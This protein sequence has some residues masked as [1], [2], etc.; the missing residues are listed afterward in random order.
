MHAI[1]RFFLNDKNILVLILINA[2]II[3]LQGFPPTEINQEYLHLFLLID[4]ILSII[5]LVEV[6]VKSRHYGWKEYIKSDWNKLDVFL[7]ALSVPPLM[8]YF[9]SVNNVQVG[10]LLIFRVFRVFKFF[11][12]VKFFPDMDHIIRSVRLAINASFSVLAGFI[13]LVFIISIMSCYFYQNLAPQYFG[14]P[15]LSFYS[16]FKIFTVEGWNT[17]P[18]EI[19]K[20]PNVSY[21]TAFFTKT[22]FVVLLFLGGIYGLSIVN[23][24]FVD[25]MVSDNNEELEEH[26]NKIEDEMKNLHRKLDRIVSIIEKKQDE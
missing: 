8:L 7:V 10:F 20:N 21:T 11:R 23:S 17:I 5:F 26:V 14:N 9:F 1:K 24:I 2:I 6:I 13:L 4:D 3:F 16:I 15:V 18:D 25:A 12:F 19:C 22:Y